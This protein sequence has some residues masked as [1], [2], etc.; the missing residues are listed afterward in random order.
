[1]MEDEQAELG[2]QLE[3]I[4]EMALIEV[5]KMQ[6]KVS[7]AV[8]DINDRVRVFEDCLAGTGQ[9]VHGA[10]ICAQDKSFMASRGISSLNTSEFTLAR[11]TV[12][13]CG[14]AW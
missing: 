5:L 9:T 4:W 3:E 13:D 6:D 11:S 7:R 1:M 2:Q 8:C 12:T 10:T 14:M